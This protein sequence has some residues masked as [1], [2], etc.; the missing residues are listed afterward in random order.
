LPETQTQGTVARRLG[1]IPNL[2]LISCEPL[3]LI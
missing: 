3:E 1:R 2:Y